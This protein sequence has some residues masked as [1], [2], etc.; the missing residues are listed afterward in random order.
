MAEMTANQ[1]YVWQYYLRSWGI[2]EQ[3]WCKRMDVTE[4]FPTATRNVGS[5]RFFYELEELAPED[6][7]YVEQ[8]ISKSSDERLRE[9][10][11][12]WVRNFQSTFVLRRHLEDR[13][14]STDLRQKL[15]TE[16]RN[17]EKMLIETYHGRM[18]DRA[19]PLLDAL[20][21]SDA[22][23]HNDEHQCADFI[24]YIC[25]QYFRTAKIRNAV[26][27][28]RHP[29]RFNMK[30][31]WPIEAFIYATNIG[32]S[33]FRQRH[34]YRVVF[35]QNAADIPFITGDQPVINLRDVADEALDFYYPLT[36][37]LAMIYTADRGLYPEDIIKAGSIMVEGYN[38]QI[39]SHSDSQIYGT[40]PAY[41]R[42]LAKF[43]KTIA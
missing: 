2:P 28:I 7:A 23:F 34:A 1:H 16:L 33:L 15:E 12:G 43:P 3:I 31:T 18:E 24:Q 27:A 22:L 6:L 17:I 10:N 13:N 35:L 14:L 5:Q 20:R 26:A 11:R 42:A 4:P 19:V 41:L 38:F 39:Y 40:E 37:R 21:C 36:P 32:A 29:F 25:L 30:R 8:I 9:L